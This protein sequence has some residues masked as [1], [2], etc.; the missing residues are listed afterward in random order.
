[1]HV[2]TSFVRNLGDLIRARARHAGPVQEG[3]SRTM[4]MHADENSDGVIVPE[5]RPNKEGLPSAEAV[6]GRTSPK[7]NGRETAAV[8][9]QGRKAASNGLV[10]VHQM[11]RQTARGRLTI[12]LRSDFRK[13][14]PWKATSATR[15]TQTALRARSSSSIGRTGDT[16]CTGRDQTVPLTFS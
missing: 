13:Q 11:A 12:G 3:N 14:L 1:M 4:N 16:M 6:E 5:K 2:E 15:I 8:R 10:A 9:T 7:G